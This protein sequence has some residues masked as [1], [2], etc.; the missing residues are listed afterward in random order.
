MTVQ[1]TALSQSGLAVESRAAATQWGRITAWT[2]L[3]AATIIAAIV[4]LSFVKAARADAIPQKRT[5]V[6]RGRESAVV[7]ATEIRLADIAEV[8][9]QSIADDDAVVAL[10]T[11]VLGASPAPGTA[12]E[13]QAQSILDKLIAAGVDLRRVGYIFPRKIAVT[14]PGRPVQENELRQAL[15]QFFLQQKRQATV[16]TIQ[17]PAGVMVPVSDIRF[18]VETT[19]ERGANP[20]PV[21]FTVK[22]Q[23][24]EVTRFQTS[25]NYDEWRE[26]PIARRTLP[27]GS[28]VMPEDTAMAR[29]NVKA[30]P[31]DAS[32]DASRVLGLKVTQDVLAGDVFRSSAL[33]VPPIVASGDKVSMV[34]RSGPLEA[35]ATG[36][37]LD[38]GARGDL[39]KVRNEASKKIIQAVVIEPGQVEVRP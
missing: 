26:A 35:T 3:I 18:E 11:I 29:L 32:L 36:V 20:S 27:R 25:V 4:S 13:L 14:R 19:G 12:T 28:I 31:K 1:T 5:I 34:I 9:A 21:V 2:V 7:T 16:Q 33:L 22:E 24:R 30:L 38:A 15:E 6:V 17:A 23:G 39:I 37:A 8:S 10:Q